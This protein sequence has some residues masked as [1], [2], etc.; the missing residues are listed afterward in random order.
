MEN[1]VFLNSSMLQNI[2]IYDIHKNQF[3]FWPKC[4][5]IACWEFNISTHKE[6][7]VHNINLQ[8]C[9]HIALIHL[10]WHCEVILITG[11]VLKS[12]MPV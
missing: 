6:T 8:V 9:T 10:E 5:Y 4:I 2:D 7:F 11:V 1:I 3:P 12:N